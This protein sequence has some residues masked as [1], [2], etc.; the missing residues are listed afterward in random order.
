MTVCYGLILLHWILFERAKTKVQ[1]SMVKIA[2][3]PAE[4]DEGATQG[5]QEA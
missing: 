3:I 2:Q 1:R 5:S 4:P